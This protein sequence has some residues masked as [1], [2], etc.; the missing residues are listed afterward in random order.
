MTN[1]V[2]SSRLFQDLREIP[3]Y[4]RN[5]GT[6]ICKKMEDMIAGAIALQKL[7]EIVIEHGSRTITA[8]ITLAVGL[9]YISSGQVF[10]GS[11]ATIA[12]LAEAINIWEAVNPKNDIICLLNDANA[13]VGMIKTLEEANGESFKIVDTN[14]NIIRNKIKKMNDQMEKIK[15]IAVEG[16]TEIE[17]LKKEASELYE[18]AHE[19]FL[20]AKNS[21][22]KSQKKFTQANTVF[23]EASKKFEELSSL[24][25]ETDL[26][27]C[28]KL[29]SFIEIAKKIQVECLLGQELMEKGNELI[30]CGMGCLDSA[31]EKEIEAQGK[32]V[33][34]M[35]RA[36]SKLA[37]IEAQ[38]V[39]KREYEAKVDETKDELD[40]IKARN[41]DVK[42][43]LQEISSDLKE[44]R[45]LS[46]DKFGTTSIVLGV[47]PGA[48]AGFSAGGFT[49]AVLGGMGGGT[50][51]HSRGEI[52]A[53]ID[54]LVNGPIIFVEADSN[55]E[56]L[57]KVKF[58]SRPSGWFNR[59]VKQIPQSFTVGVIDITIG[60]SVVTFP[61]NLNKNSPISKCNLYE[62]Q[63]VLGK[64]VV[65][66]EITA[67]E[68]LDIISE[69]EN[70]YI[71]RGQNHKAHT[72]LIASNSSYFTE[73]KRA[74]S[75]LVEYEE[76]TDDEIIE[77]V[78]NF[79][80]IETSPCPEDWDGV[81]VTATEC[82]P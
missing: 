45:K 23:V 21:F 47:I 48:V 9:G 2:D 75:K 61:F 19:E 36:K 69:L 78:V 35:E 56:E 16:Q 17:I 64:K 18:D 7:S 31:H 39:I 40:H 33:I 65:A 22:K 50:F 46:E 77:G 58:S 32:I 52:A 41:Q 27:D 38:A 26:T 34:A 24:A 44:A 51:V 60:N 6:Y 10:K 81:W 70:K 68:C 15:V 5:I 72:G 55:Q 12:G 11:V 73:L 8:G 53:K 71:E 25:Q 3:E 82:F 76:K 66:N 14:L 30:N 29:N 43:L 62:L 1:Y 74:C 79:I 67:Q 28:E 13:G 80:E 49:G 20:V 63:Q 42:V 37:I 59:F 4:Q 57:V 54:N